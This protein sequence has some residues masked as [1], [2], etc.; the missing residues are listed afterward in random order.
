MAPITDE[1]KTMHRSDAERSCSSAYASAGEGGTETTDPLKAQ[2][3]AAVRTR[4]IRA[5]IEGMG[6]GYVIGMSKLLIR[7][8]GTRFGEL[9]EAVAGRILVADSDQ[10]HRWADRMFSATTLDD[11]LASD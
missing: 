3:E 7:L 2:L 10:I 1:T 11:V 6:A 5:Y 8:L 9:P 4:E